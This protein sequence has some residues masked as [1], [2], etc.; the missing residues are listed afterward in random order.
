MDI[1]IN[2][3]DKIGMEINK[4]PNRDE[5]AAQALK[6]MLEENRQSLNKISTTGKWAKFAEEVRRES[7]LH[8]LSEEFNKTSREFRDNFEFN[9]DK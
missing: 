6:N 7:P 1:I 2:V 5:L 9:H 8:E 3:P 4:L